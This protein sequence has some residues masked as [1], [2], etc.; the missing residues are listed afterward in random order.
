MISVSG[1]LSASFFIFLFLENK[2][3]HK[4][5]VSKLAILFMKR[6]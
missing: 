1:S 6:S 4:V 3:W 5:S 2:V